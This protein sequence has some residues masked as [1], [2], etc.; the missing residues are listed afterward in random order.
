MAATTFSAWAGCTQELKGEP[1]GVIIVPE[2]DQG[3]LIF[4][5]CNRFWEV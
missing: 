2:N 3:S 4:I 1:A 5:R